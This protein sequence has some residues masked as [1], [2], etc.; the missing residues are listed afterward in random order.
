MYRVIISPEAE[1]DLKKLNKKEPTA[2]KKVKALLLEL[3]QH[4]TT[5]TGKI[6]QLKHCDQ[7]TWSRRI[8]KKHRLVYRVCDDVVEVLVLS[9]YG[10]YD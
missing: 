9:A 10:H 1:R 6:E 7:E 5:G 8:N 4:P 2:I 3:E